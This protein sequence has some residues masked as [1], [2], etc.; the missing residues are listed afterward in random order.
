M[1]KLLLL[2]TLIYTG[3]MSA[4]A[5][6]YDRGEGM[7]YDDV[8]DITWLQDMNYARLS[9]YAE[10][11]KTE[12]ETSVWG[13]ITKSTDIDEYGNMGWDAAKQWVDQLTITHSTY[14]T[15][16]DWRLPSAK[17][18]SEQYTEESGYDGSGPSGY[19]I[20]A[21]EIGHM[22]H[23]YLGNKSG[24]LPNGEFQRTDDGFLFSTYRG[25]NGD[26]EFYNNGYL[27]VG[28]E[29]RPIVY[30]LWL[31]EGEEVV[32]NY[33]TAWYFGGFA[34]Y[35]GTEKKRELMKAW[36]VRD[37]DVANVSDVPVPAAA[38]LFG[39]ALAGLVAFRKKK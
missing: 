39:S 2:S 5:T 25:P 31:N 18:D 10:A 32:S 1:K 3:V 35:Q 12:I 9:G 6:L 16:D 30:H 37:G 28:F 7:I 8:F 29:G 17:L 22:V 13:D 14:G 34:G 24:Y 15:F 20:V 38:W 21:S 36:A 33:A 11:N 4:N 19:N 23:T 27:G 26:I